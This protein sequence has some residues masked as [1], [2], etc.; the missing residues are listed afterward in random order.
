[1]VCLVVATAVTRPSG[2]PTTT[3]SPGRSEGPPGEAQG[4][5]VEDL[6]GNLVAAGADEAAVRSLVREAVRLG[7][8]RRP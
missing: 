5:L 7:Q 6:V 2:S 4:A 8:G 3:G 1:V